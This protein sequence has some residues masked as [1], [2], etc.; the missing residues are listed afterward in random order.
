MT[1]PENHA[2]LLVDFFQRTARQARLTG[3]LSLP[4]DVGPAFFERFQNVLGDA[5]EIRVARRGDYLIGFLILLYGPDTVFLRFIGLDYEA[6]RDALFRLLYD[7]IEA[8]I[9]RK[10]R[11]VDMGSGTTHVKAPLGCRQIP[12]AYSIRFQRRLR[13]VRGILTRMLN[14][15]FA[16]ASDRKSEINTATGTSPEQRNLCP[17]R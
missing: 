6:S 13:P 11:Y 2:L 15:R 5:G 4:L 14:R 8:A 10:L 1:N 7:G 3:S 9:R 12:T 17:I 16:T